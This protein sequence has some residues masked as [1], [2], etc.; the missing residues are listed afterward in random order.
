MTVSRP[1]F[2]IAPADTVADLS[3]LI[4]AMPGPEGP[5]LALGAS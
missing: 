5:G 1:L 2:P 4:V 3:Y